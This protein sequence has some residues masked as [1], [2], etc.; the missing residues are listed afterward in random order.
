MNT[1][2]MIPE[3]LSHWTAQL[4]PLVGRLIKSVRYLTPQE[5]EGLGWQ[6]S[7][8]V[9]ELDD[10]TLIYPSQDDEGNDA[11]TFF[12]QAGRKTKGLPDGAPVIQ[13]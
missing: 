3:P 8:A 4:Q 5:V 13:I 10:G 12:L 9:L 1:P 7:T 6:V 11:G 2:T